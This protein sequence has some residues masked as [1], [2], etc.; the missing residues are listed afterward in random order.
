[1]NFLIKHKLGQSR[2]VVQQI[3]SF[4]AGEGLSR[5][6]NW[7]LMALLPFFLSTT[8][9]YGKIGLLV[10][11]EML[12]SNISLLGLDRAVL[13]FYAKDEEP[14]RLLRCVLVIW[15]ALAWIPLAAVLVLYFSG[16]ETFFG[17]PLAPH[18]FL[19]SV[20]VVIFNLNFLCVCIGRAKHHLGVFLRF[21][22]CYG[23]LK[24]VGVLLMAK[25]LGH[26]LSYV[27]GMGV[28]VLVMLIFIIPFLRRRVGAQADRAV[29]GQLLIFGWPFVF[30]VLSGNILSYFSRFFL[31]AYTSTKDVGIF[32]FAFTLGGA[33]YVGY[34]ALGTYF[35]PRIYSHAD[36]KS[37]CEKWL[38]LYTNACITFASAAGASLLFVYPYLT[39][40]LNVDYGSALPT[41]SMV[42]GTILLT[43][44]YL[45][46]NYRLTAHKKTGYIAAASFL[47]ACLSIALNY[48]L[49]PSHGIW[50]AAMAMYVS[51]FL[52]C[53]I[54]L[55][56]SIRTARISLHQ[57]YS[58]PVY[59]LCSFG[60]LCVLLWAND[61]ALAILAL[62]MVCL[63]SSGLLF[64]VFLTRGGRTA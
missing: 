30:H 22:L 23:V 16:R 34:A 54:I 1:M 15:A 12:V 5:G 8:E 20:I 46:G 63:V 59:C 51:N 21:R 33:L 25:L 40:H 2:G 37:R 61:S 52:L 45:Q 56:V 53:G 11:I 31:E 10:S 62:L 28:A 17:I 19:L 57:L 50:G 32:T 9:E 13:R 36:D 55:V 18:L 43:P 64:R 38:A 6:L 24:F 49:V 29:V 14:G 58:M 7:G 41:I 42:M 44:L 27:L 4:G 3:V 35:E 39:P 47:S 60:S 26:S 48:L